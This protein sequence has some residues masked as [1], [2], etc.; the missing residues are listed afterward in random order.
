MLI[1]EKFRL[2]ALLVA[3]LSSLRP[4]RLLALFALALWRRRRL[5]QDWSIELYVV[6]KS[7]KPSLVH[8]L[9]RT[10]FQLLANELLYC[11]RKNG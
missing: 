5:G 10:R 2:T 3:I 1:L 9:T 7:L 4:G 6:D 11:L 8:I